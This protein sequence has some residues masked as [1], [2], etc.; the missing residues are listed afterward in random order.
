MMMTIQMV[1]QLRD[2]IK[3]LKRPSLAN[4]QFSLWDNVDCDEAS[5]YQ[6]YFAKWNPDMLG[7]KSI[8]NMLLSKTNRIKRKLKSAFST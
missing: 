8:K 2:D 3:N 4:F 5:N 7:S 1:T 6:Y